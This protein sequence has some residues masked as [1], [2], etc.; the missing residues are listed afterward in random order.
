MP[1]EISVAV[2]NSGK[3][4]LPS[5][6]RSSRLGFSRCGDLEAP[7]QTTESWILNESW[8][9]LKSLYPSRIRLECLCLSARLLLFHG[10]KRKGEND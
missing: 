4:L 3:S 1:L 8:W 9:F 7:H 5:I 10:G 2:C 6:H